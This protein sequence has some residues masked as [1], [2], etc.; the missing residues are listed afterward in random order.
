[1]IYFIFRIDRKFNFD[2][3]AMKKAVFTFGS[4]GDYQIDNYS[5][6]FQHCCISWE[7]DKLKWILKEPAC[8]VLGTY[9]SL[10]TAT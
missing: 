9:F 10:K 5:L 4:K 3:Y 7:N 2:T 1:M 6:A 8:T